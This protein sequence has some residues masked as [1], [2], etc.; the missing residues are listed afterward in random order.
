M[1]ES[2]SEKFLTEMVPCRDLGKRRNGE[3]RKEEGSERWRRAEKIE[4][5]SD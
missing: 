3:R 2:L 5:G 1:A 4:P